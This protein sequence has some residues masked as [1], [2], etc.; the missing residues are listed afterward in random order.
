M[1]N[2]QENNNNDF[3]HREYKDMKRINIIKIIVFFGIILVP[4]I[5][6]NLKQDQVSEIDNR[7]LMNLEDIFKEGDISYNIESYL[8][9][10]IGFRSNMVNVYNNSMDKLFQELVHPSYEYGKDGYIF[11]KSEKSESNADFQQVYANFIRGFQNYC[12]DRGI[13]FLYAV[14]PRK[15]EVYP[16][17]IVEGFNYENKDLE[18][19][20]TILEENN[21]NFLNN[22]E[23]LVNNKDKA[24]LFDKKYDVRHWNETGAIIGI[25]AILDRLNILDSRVGNFDISKFEQEQYINRI[26]P[27]SK[28]PIEEKTIHYKLIEDNSEYISDFENEIKLDE[29]FRNFTHYKNDSNKEG[30][31]ILI[32]A[33]SYFNDKE[34][35][36]IN[37]FSEIMQIHNYRNVINYE[38]YINIYNPDIVLFE[39]TEYTHMNY[40]FPINEMRNKIYNKDLKSYSSLIQS[41]FVDIEESNLIKSDSKLSNFSIPI[42]S[43]DVLFAYAY[44]NNRILDCKIKKIDNQK[45]VEFSIMTSEIKDTN[46]FDLYF[47]SKNEERYQKIGFTLD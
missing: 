30:P 35:F 47:I 19:F 9:D 40:Y 41:S 38:Y 17:Y 13:K 33:G 20:L 21:I 11:S 7:M 6:I 34:K 10:R 36:M 1:K 26:L 12:D 45:Y 25:S 24:L 23:T 14:E 22:V 46:G 32:F 31:R 44:I 18:Y 39:S 3:K 16:E 29:K 43:D 28:F 15:E 2:E 4:I 27:V 42:Y 5:N 37:N 8:D